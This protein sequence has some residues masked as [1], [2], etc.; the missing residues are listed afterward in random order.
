MIEDEIFYVGQKAFINKNDEILVLRNP[1]E[2]VDYPGGKIQQGENNLVESLKREVREETGLE[3]SVGEP[4]V[5]WISEL[6]KN[7][8]L[9]GKKLLLIGYKCKYIS[10]EV[11]L[12]HEHDKFSWVTKD[13]YI[14]INDGTAY[15]KILEKYYSKN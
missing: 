10:G 2:G 5:T 6:P 1:T 8:Y 11:I 12:S 13:N 14:E 15:F 3:I 7:H 4:F 9:A